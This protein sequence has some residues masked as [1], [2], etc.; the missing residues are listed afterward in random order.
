MCSSSS[1]T[2]TQIQLRLTCVKAFDR[3]KKAERHLTAHVAAFDRTKMAARASPSI[4]K[5]RRNCRTTHLT[6]DTTARAARLIQTNGSCQNGMSGAEPDSAGLGGGFEDFPGK[7]AGATRMIAAIFSGAWKYAERA[8]TAPAEWLQRIRRMDSVL[9]IKCSQYFRTTRIPDGHEIHLTSGRR[10]YY[11]GL[12][13]KPVSQT[14]AWDLAFSR[15]GRFG[16]CRKAASGL[17]I[18]VR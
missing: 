2:E 6:A 1:V 17:S 12:D 10:P 11:Y 7:M 3:P 14:A 9:G 4:P 5:P 16:Q 15:S 8:T 13:R 18:K